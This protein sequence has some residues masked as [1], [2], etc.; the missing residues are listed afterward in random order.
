MNPKL[1]YETIINNSVYK[2]FEYSSNYY[3]IEKYN[4]TVSSE[5]FFNNLKD[6]IRFIQIK[7]SLE[8]N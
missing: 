7:K 4:D 1:I 2:V 8:R 3:K 5:Y 6:C